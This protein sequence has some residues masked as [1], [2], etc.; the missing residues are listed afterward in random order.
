MSS[1]IKLL[2]TEQIPGKRKI[3]SED[4]KFSFLGTIN[5]MKSLSLIIKN[6]KEL[7]DNYN[8][9]IKKHIKSNTY[10]YSS[11]ISIIFENILM[12]LHYFNSLKIINSQINKN[13]ATSVVRSQIVNWYYI[14]YYSAKAMIWAHNKTYQENHASVAKAW[15]QLVTKNL[16]MHPFDL[17]LNTLIK[18]DYEGYI[19]EYKVQFEATNSPRPLN[20][21]SENTNDAHATIIA[22]L[23]GTA[24]F[25]R[26]KA[27][28]EIKENN[29]LQS[30]RKDGA[31]KIRD[32]KLEKKQ[33]N[34]L[35]EAFRYR[36]K[37]NYRDSLFLAY[38]KEDKKE[39][40]IFELLKN[41]EIVSRTFVEMALIFIKN[42]ANTK[43]NRQYFEEFYKDLKQHLL[44]NC[45]LIDKLI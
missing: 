9:E 36:G 44:F 41:L 3:H 30:F 8:N 21:T 32:K 24:N 35:H 45:E 4:Y 23:K 29:K 14:L 16:I 19:K 27:E 12:S 13:F 37:A 39:D 38:K 42:K 25:Y 1:Y 40:E 22:Y 43:K 31:R 2:E 15:H 20:N 10:Q 17:H 18:R 7:L 33:I 26:E 6:D 5:W 11:D 28:K 34:F